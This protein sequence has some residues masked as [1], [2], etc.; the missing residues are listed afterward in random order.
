MEE[1][2]T[3]AEA[4]SVTKKSLTLE[5]N[6]ARGTRPRYQAQDVPGGPQRLYTAVI[7][8]AL[9]RCTDVAR[10]DPKAL[11][12]TKEYSTLICLSGW[13][14]SRVGTQFSFSIKS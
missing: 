10:K 13:L 4:A 3:I 14:T 8:F 12:K 6:G 11:F 5:E 7:H 2:A 1:T 9:A